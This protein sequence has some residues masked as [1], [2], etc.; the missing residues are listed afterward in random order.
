MKL[1]PRYQL[2]RIINYIPKP[3][4]YITYTSLSPLYIA[5]HRKILEGALTP[6]TEGQWANETTA[7]LFRYG[8]AVIRA[9]LPLTNTN[10]SIQKEFSKRLV[11]KFKFPQGTS[12]FQLAKYSFGTNSKFYVER[13]NEELLFI[14]IV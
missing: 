2:S 14:M 13:E 3:P 7:P 5:K 8:C 6:R 12:E 10:S 1:S 11:V 4:L 9:R